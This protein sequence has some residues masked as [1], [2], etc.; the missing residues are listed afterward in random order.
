MIP[1]TAKLLIPPDYRF[2]TI[3]MMT[4]VAV[5]GKHNKIVFLHYLERKFNSEREKAPVVIHKVN[6]K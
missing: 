3:I 2:L 5:V 1:M 4:D 6:V